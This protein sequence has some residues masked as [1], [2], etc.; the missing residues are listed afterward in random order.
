[1]PYGASPRQQGFSPHAGKSCFNAAISPA[2]AKRRKDANLCFFCCNVDWTAPAKDHKPSC[3]KRTL[4]KDKV[5]VSSLELG[6]GAVCEN[7]NSSG[8][9]LQPNMLSPSPAVNLSPAGAANLLAL[10]QQQ[11]VSDAELIDAAIA[12]VEAQY[13]AMLLS[14]QD[15]RCA[16]HTAQLTVEGGFNPPSTQSANAAASAAAQGNTLVAAQTTTPN[17]AENQQHVDSIFSVVPSEL[18]AIQQ[19]AGR[20]FTLDAAVFHAGISSPIAS[21]CCSDQEPFITKDLAGQHI[22]VCVSFADLKDH[23]DH[24]IQQKQKGPQHTSAC[25]VVPKWRVLPHPAL[26]GM[27]IIKEYRQG[28]HLFQRGKKRF[29]GLSDPA[30]VYY[31]PPSPTL[32]DSSLQ[33]LVMQYKCHVHGCKATTL[34]DTGAQGFCYVNRT[35]LQVNNIKYIGTAE[36]G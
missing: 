21:Q 26:S 5:D 1:V 35:L 4:S 19:L 25:F 12:D 9:L 18:Q 33:K 28:Y 34:L 2:E 13:A 31:A 29:S 6:G 7:S 3:P 14:Q 10:T 36:P 22:W 20:G 27:Q 17:A 15:Q 24:Y 11:G 30:L 32:P 16:A 8:F 23:V